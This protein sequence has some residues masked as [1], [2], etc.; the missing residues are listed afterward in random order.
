MAAL[1]AKHRIYETGLDL[2]M[3]A[4]SVTASWTTAS[5]GRDFE[6]TTNDAIPDFLV[7]LFLDF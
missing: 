1:V 4:V 2:D 3:T 6:S 5:R 7:E